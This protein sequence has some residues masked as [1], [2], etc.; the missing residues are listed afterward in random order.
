MNIFNDQT[1]QSAMRCKFEH[2]TCGK[3]LENLY[4]AE[5]ARISKRQFQE[6]AEIAG[7]ITLFAQRL[8]KAEA[9]K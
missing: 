3:R 1:I 2:G 7:H 4:V 5:G 8:D 9:G 6:M